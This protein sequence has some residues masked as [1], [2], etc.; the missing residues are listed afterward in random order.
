[1][2]VY[3][4]PGR[5]AIQL[6]TEDFRTDKNHIWSD[7]IPIRIREDSVEE[8]LSMKEIAMN[9]RIIAFFACSVISVGLTIPA[10]A[11]EATGVVGRVNEDDAA[12]ELTDGSVYLL[13]EILEVSTI[14]PGMEVHLIYEMTP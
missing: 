3:D 8:P 6:T 1:M 10:Q 13:P 5:K 9:R 11:E 14:R 2:S 12:L 7:K 4:L